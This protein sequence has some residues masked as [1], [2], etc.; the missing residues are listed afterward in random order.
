MTH[1]HREA[2]ER[3]FRF[4]LTAQ[5]LQQ[6]TELAK[7]RPAALWVGVERGDDH[8]PTKV[9]IWKFHHLARNR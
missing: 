3:V 9:E 8:Q 2:A 1:S 4:D 5:H 6:R 7:I